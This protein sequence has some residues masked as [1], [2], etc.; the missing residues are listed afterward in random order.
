MVVV[1]IGQ[2]NT[3]LRVLL[4]RPHKP[5]LSPVGGRTP[6]LGHTGEGCRFPARLGCACALAVNVSL[7]QAHGALVCRGE[8][9]RILLAIVHSCL[10]H[11]AAADEALLV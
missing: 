3:A 10:P 9:S 5:E 2:R 6:T 11:N 4:K 1:S 8:G 7:E